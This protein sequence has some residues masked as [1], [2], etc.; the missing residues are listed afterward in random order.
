MERREV[1]WCRIRHISDTFKVKTIMPQKLIDRETPE[2]VFSDLRE[3][4][5]SDE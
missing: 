5:V 2:T 1:T 3:G 4:A